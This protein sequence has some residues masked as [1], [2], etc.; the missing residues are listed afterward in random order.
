M[1][2]R[3][4]RNL[5]DVSASSASAMEPD[6][7]PAPANTRNKVPSVSARVA[8]SPSPLASDQPTAPNRSRDRTARSLVWHPW[9]HR[10]ACRRSPVSGASPGKIQRRYRIILQDAVDFGRQMPHGIRVD[11]G[12]FGRNLQLQYGRKADATASI[13]MACSYRSL[14]DDSALSP[15]ADLQRDRRFAPQSLPTD[16]NAPFFVISARLAPNSVLVDATASG[17][18]VWDNSGAN[19]T[20]NVYPWE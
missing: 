8:H 3:I 20:A 17:L 14:A 7:I 16:F 19:G 13:T 2:A 11:E 15:A 4:V 18:E 6:T 9:P 10:S 5:A 12:R 1:V